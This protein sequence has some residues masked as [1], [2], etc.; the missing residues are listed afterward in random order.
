MYRK[1]NKKAHSCGASAQYILARTENPE[2]RPSISSNLSMDEATES[3]RRVVSRQSSQSIC[4]FVSVSASCPVY[5][6]MYMRACVILT[7]KR[8]LPSRLCRVSRRIRNDRRNRLLNNANC[9]TESRAGLKRQPRDSWNEIL[10]RV[11]TSPPHR[12]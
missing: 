4:I 8:E 9:R 10:V 2:L 3:R 7:S 11:E 12:K 5:V 6:C 1:K